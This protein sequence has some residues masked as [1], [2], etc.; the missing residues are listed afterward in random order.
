M[1]SWSGTA[2]LRWCL[3]ALLLVG[4]WLVTG[5]VVANAAAGASE[6]MSDTLFLGPSVD[7]FLDPSGAL[8]IDD[9]ARQ[10]GLFTKA[11]GHTPNRGVSPSPQAAFWLRVHVPALAT[12]R[13]WVLSLDDTRIVRATLYRR[14]SDGWVSQEWSL[15]HQ[16]TADRSSLSYPNFRL[17]R[18]AIADQ[19]LYLRVQTT[20]SMRGMLWLESER[21]FRVGH[22]RQIFASGIL[23]GVLM[24][25]L[26]YLLAI[27]LALSDG[28]LL[29]LSVLV[30][31]FVVYL[32]SDRALLETLVIPGAF[33]LSRTV[34]LS[35][36]LLIFPAW[37]W[38]EI[39]YL[40]VRAYLPR[41]AVAGK[42]LALAVTACA[43]EAAVETI[44]GIRVMR[45]YSSY[46]GLGSLAFG[47]GLAAV[48]LR[49]KRR[50]ALI[51]ILCWSPAI[52]G[53]VA[54]LTLD[55][56]P[57]IG[58]T[59]LLANAVY[60]GVALSLFVFGIMTSLDLQARERRLRAKAEASESRFRSFADSASDTFWETDRDGRIISITGSSGD[61][62][63]LKAG[64][65]LIERLQA[66]SVEAERPSATLLGEYLAQRRP[67][68]S[69]LLS[70]RAV[71]GALH[72]AS[73]S[74]APVIGHDGAYL[75]HRGVLSDVTEET[76]LRERQIQQQ[77]MAALGQLAGGIAH[78]INNLLHP[79]L[80]LSRRVRE[81]LRG[82]DELYYQMGLVVDAT[83]QAREIVANVLTSARPSLQA[84]PTLPFQEAL[85]RS[86]ESV[87]PLLPASVTLQVELSGDDGPS[88]PAGEVLQIVSNLVSNAVHAVHGAGTIII[89]TVTEEETGSLIFSIAD[90]G[91][92]MDTETRRK[93][94]EPFFTTKAP[95]GGTGLGLP[96]VYGIVSG[97]GA[98]IDIVSERGQGT[99]IVIRIPPTL[100]AKETRHESN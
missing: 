83:T 65:G 41:A 48:A 97:W 36:S 6:P 82:Q 68:R 55:A 17:L 59:R 14:G 66:H 4:C 51:F 87:H 35:S 96:L 9:L 72:H 5:R 32:V 92:G 63:D 75:G 46:I 38:F 52:I 15:R 19:V 88:V 54:R 29:R 44:L 58:P 98:S 74:G 45:L 21:A 99:T 18:S 43:I 23:V 67:F 28:S 47:L 1:R 12:D 22:D 50:D 61:I 2:P 7:H 81:R 13:D 62:A 27:G 24:G 8:G 25:L 91:E 64:A 78:E 90:D 95:S 11:D 39:H 40:K 80:N 57:N 94:L 71:S 56:I 76:V 69:V 10:D 85:A 70:V 73:F 84:S 53:G 16:G 77:K 60:F 100:Q 26:V 34:S 33:D 20:S 89:A 79:I 86:I 30:L 49:Y 31:I 37:L 3:A 93:A 42:F